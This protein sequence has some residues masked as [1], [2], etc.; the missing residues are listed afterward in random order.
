MKKGGGNAGLWTRRKN[1]KPG[2]PPRPR[3]LGNRQKRAIP[4]FPPA[5]TTKPDGKVEIQKQDSHFPTGAIPYI[6]KPKKGGLA[7]GRFAPAFQA[8][9]A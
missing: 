2:F 9:L 5:S 4:T 8:H 1:P 3:A 7:A 6:Q